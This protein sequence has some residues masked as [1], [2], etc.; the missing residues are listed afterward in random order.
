MKPTMGIPI[1]RKKRTII[2]MGW[3]FGMALVLLPVLLTFGAIDALV[4]VLIIIVLI[5]AAATL[6][7]GWNALNIFGIGVLA[8]VA[9]QAGQGAR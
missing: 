4:P 1:Y 7:R 9:G 2:H 3:V 5:A 8:G 6:T